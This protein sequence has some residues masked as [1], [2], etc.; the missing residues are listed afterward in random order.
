MDTSLN[1]LVA[2]KKLKEFSIVDVSMGF[3]KDVGEKKLWIVTECSVV[4]E[5]TSKINAPVRYDLYTTAVL[6]PV[7]QAAAQMKKEPE[8]NNH[9][10]NK[11]KV[12]KANRFQ[13]RQTKK[14]KKTHN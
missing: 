3:T 13:P 4:A 12:K 14:R 10:T 1:E 11:R 6:A 5:R 7:E 8:K 2:S 9:I